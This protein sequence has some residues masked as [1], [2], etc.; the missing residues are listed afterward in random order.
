MSPNARMKIRQMVLREMHEMGM[1]QM[2]QAGR[3]FHHNGPEQESDMIKSNLFTM[4]GKAY[5]LHD[6]IG[7]HDDLPEWVQ[8]KIAVA[9]SMIDSVHDYLSYEYHKF[10]QPEMP[11][12]M[13]HSGM[14]LMEKKKK[15]GRVVKGK[16]HGE[17]YKSSSAMA[18]AIEKGSSYEDLK[19][20]AKWA[21]NPD[22]VV[23]A[24]LMAVKGKPARKDEG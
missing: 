3:I 10:N 22:A 8:E 2:D 4:G 18:K 16:Y 6:M 19:K 1:S 17:T 13:D 15:N 20:M 7:D 12:E 14:P 5:E 23:N 24:A 21:N 9:G 11:P